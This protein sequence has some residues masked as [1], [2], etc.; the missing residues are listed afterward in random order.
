MLR[1][2]IQTLGD[3]ES[4]DG[5]GR[6]RRTRRAL[7]VHYYDDTELISSE[8]NSEDDPI[9]V[10]K[11]KA[12]KERRASSRMPS[13]R[14]SSTGRSSHLRGGRTTDRYSPSSEDSGI[15]FSRTKSERHPVSHQ[16]SDLERPIRRVRSEVVIADDRVVCKTKSERYDLEGRPMRRARSE[17]GD[18]EENRAPSV[19]SIASENGCGRCSRQQRRRAIL[20]ETFGKQVLEWEPRDP[21]REPLPVLLGKVM[22]RSRTM[23]Q[24][25]EDVEEVK[26]GSGPVLPPSPA[27]PTRRRTI[28]CSASRPPSMEDCAAD[29]DFQTDKLERLAAERRAK[30]EPLAR[31]EQPRKGSVPALARACRSPEEVGSMRASRKE[32]GPPSRSSRRSH[33]LASGESTM[34]PLGGITPSLA[35]TPD[36]TGHARRRQFPLEVPPLPF[37]D[38]TEKGPAGGLSTSSGGF[39]FEWKKGRRLGSGSSGCVFAALSETGRIFAVKQSAECAEDSADA[40]SHREKLEEELQICQSLKHPN[41]V[42]YLGHDWCNNQLHL[43]L[44]YMPGGSMAAVLSDFGRLHAKQLSKATRDLFTGLNY[45]HTRTPPVVHRDIKGANL[46][47]SLSFDV[48]LADFG[49]SRRN[50]ETRSMTMLGSIP[51]MAPEVIQQQDGHGRKADIWSAGCTVIEMATAEKPWGTGTFDNVMFALAH[52]G[53]TQALPAVPEDI[54]PECQD[55]IRQCVQR[56]VQARPSSRDVLRHSPYIT[57]ESTP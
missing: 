24:L 13:E 31:R 34:T 14:S 50:Q 29:L 4:S 8:T 43:Y 18:T 42:S 25:A 47:V 38:N 32:G 11:V 3:E 46:L 36:A 51:W 55:L 30:L 41:T 39:S 20:A 45:L 37:A 9:M 16:A 7:T 10:H 57:A 21:A 15:F 44:E 40:Q 52:I 28:D 17:R 48:K 23:P 1:P 27:V 33:S 26:G 6:V 49:L 56:S 19:G 54:A 2:T 53:M 22:V 12:V 35:S 5:G